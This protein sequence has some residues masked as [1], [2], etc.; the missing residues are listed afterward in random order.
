MRCALGAGAMEH[1]GMY[2]IMSATQSLAMMMGGTT[3]SMTTTRTTICIGVTVL[4]RS[5]RVDLTS[6]GGIM[7]Q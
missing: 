5:S 7:L 4:A 6:E 2:V 1:M 3:M